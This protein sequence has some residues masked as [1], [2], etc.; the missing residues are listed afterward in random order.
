MLLKLYATIVVVFSFSQML[1]ILPDVE[2]FISE[3]NATLQ[4]AIDG[5]ERRKDELRTKILDLQ[6][7]KYRL[8][9]AVKRMEILLKSRIPSE[10]F[11]K[12]SLLPP[13]FFI[14]PT[15]FRATQKADLTRLAQTLHAVPNLVWVIVEDALEFSD[16]VSSI[17]I[18]SGL[19]YGHLLKSTPKEKKYNGSEVHGKGAW[20]RNHA[21]AWIRK[22][23][24][25][26]KRGVIYFGDDD[27]T[28]DWRLFDEMRKI[29]KVGV[30][31][32][33]TVGG[34]VVEGPIVAENG[35]LIGFDAKWRPKRPFP[36]DM[37]AF[38]VNISLLHAHPQ[39]KFNY[40]AFPGDM[41]SSFLVSLKLKKVDL[42]PRANQGS[43]VY[44]WHTRTANPTL[45][46]QDKR[47]LRGRTNLTILERSAF[48]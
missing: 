42:E 13:I 29:N 37:A 5:L 20:Q 17:L 44:V 28:Y 24:A 26:L 30:W 33:G 21:L 23:F 8:D 40:T 4:A 10:A 27:N 41:E 14:T 32:V 47:R 15:Y 16:S 1:L 34:Q 11:L 12:S 19:Q 48:F 46:A 36:I 45:S 25:D 7:E 9:V 6:S 2:N 22:N 38:A 18:S 35:I 31:P 43:K 3:R 39:A